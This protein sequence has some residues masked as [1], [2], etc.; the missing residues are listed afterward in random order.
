MPILPR[1]KLNSLNGSW[2]VTCTVP[3]VASISPD[4]RLNMV[5]LPQPVLPSTATI[6][7]FSIVND[8]PSTAVKVPTPSG[9]G[10]CLVTSR[11]R[12]N[13]SATTSRRPFGNSAIAQEISLD[14]AERRLRHQ[15]EQH[16]LQSPGDGARHV[17]QLLLQQQLI[18]DAAGRA[19]QFGDHDDARGVAEVDLEGGDDARHDGRHDQH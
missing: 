18:A 10:N 4:N 12:M 17:E 6:S 8:S 2:S 9:R 13:G 7:P 19:D 16:K 14:H 15:H 3:L 11:K 1:K 5:D